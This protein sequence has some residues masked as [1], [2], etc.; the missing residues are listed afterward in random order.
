VTDKQPDNFVYL[1]LLKA[2]FPQAKFIC[3]IRNPLDVCI[4]VYF[5]H[6]G[7][8]LPYSNKLINIAHYFS[9][10]VKLIRHWKSIMAD[11]LFIVDYDNLVVSQT[12]TTEKLLKFCNLPW[13]DECLE[14]YSHKNAVKTASVWQVR[15]PIY[16]T[17]V[18]RSQH[19]AQH[20]RE[21]ESYL[22]KHLPDGYADLLS[23]I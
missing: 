23:P 14:F 3:T 16:Q 2:I 6:L 18:R 13:Q 15:Q 4:S 1:G 8:E 20:L 7:N 21:V 9:Q 12:A 19:Y 10:Y 5:Q 22:A 11:N 17:S